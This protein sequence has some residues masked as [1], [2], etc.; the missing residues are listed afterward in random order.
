[1][2]FLSFI[3]LTLQEC[4]DSFFNAQ[5]LNHLGMGQVKVSWG[6]KLGSLV[7]FLRCGWR[8]SRV[9]VNKAS[10]GL[11]KLC[12]SVCHPGV[13]WH[14]T[15]IPCSWN[16]LSW[17]AVVGSSSFCPL[18]WPA[19]ALWAKPCTSETKWPQTKILSIH[20]DA[21][22]NRGGCYFPGERLRRHQNLQCFCQLWILSTVLQLTVTWLEQDAM[23][24]FK[25]IP[26]ALCANRCSSHWCWD[27]GLGWLNMFSDL[28]AH[29]NA[30]STLLQVCA[31]DLVWF[32]YFVVIP[33]SPR[34]SPTV[35]DADKTNPRQLKRAYSLKPG[36]TLDKR[37]RSS[38][39]FIPHLWCC[40][41]LSSVLKPALRWR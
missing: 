25:C 30:V 20:L 31:A 16:R 17:W 32:N 4:E 3:I 8:V 1:M 35:L 19:A 7:E 26:C 5:I 24:F 39:D 11:C 41:C 6:W 12:A 34:H 27:G 36:C 37:W 33:S 15:R 22:G 13:S 23:Y 38:R 18:I 40:T 28:P 2:S 29:F 10:E 21:T 14:Q 9:F